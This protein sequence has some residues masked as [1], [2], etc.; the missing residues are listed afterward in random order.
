MSDDTTE[1]RPKATALVLHTSERYLYLD[2]L[3]IF[4][5]Q[6]FTL[7]DVA[8]IKGPRAT[9]HDEKMPWKSWRNMV[10]VVERLL[11]HRADDTTPV[12]VGSAPGSLAMEL[13]IQHRHAVPIIC[14]APG[15]WRMFELRPL[16][17]PPPPPLMTLT[18]DCPFNGRVL[19]MVQS[20]FQLEKKIGS[21][22]DTDNTCALFYI[23][24]D[25]GYR[26][27]CSRRL[28][29]IRAALPEGMVLEAAFVLRPAGADDVLVR[30]DPT[31]ADYN[32]H[33][34]HRDIREALLCMH[35]AVSGVCGT[36]VLMAPSTPISMLVG[37]EYGFLQL[38]PY[39]IMEI[40]HTSVVRT[41]SS[42]CFHE[43]LGM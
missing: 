12:L 38:G 1:G 33:V 29:L 10:G 34:L 25:S 30:G 21:A 17:A 6:R 40:G 36:T 31:A 9:C 16:P 28:T 2:S 35:Q 15:G 11:E 24:G 13:G 8:T 41:Y 20:G 32:Y 23:T 19:T 43:Q 18:S 22:V 4:M 39:I 7:T 27:L 3:R 42:P 37:A 5:R 14:P 26:D